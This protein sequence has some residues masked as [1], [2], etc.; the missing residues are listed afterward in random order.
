MGHPGMALLASWREIAD[1][2]GLSQYRG[3]PSYCFK[4]DALH[5]YAELSV[6]F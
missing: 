1:G 4:A 3:S 5:S 6:V 2:G